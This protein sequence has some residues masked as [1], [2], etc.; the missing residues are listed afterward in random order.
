MVDTKM[1]ESRRYL[2]AVRGH[3]IPL[4]ACVAIALVLLLLSGPLFGRP[5]PSLAPSPSASPTNYGT[6]FIVGSIGPNGTIIVT[7]SNP[8]D[9]DILVHASCKTMTGMSVNDESKATKSDGSAK[10]VLHLPDVPLTC[11]LTASLAGNETAAPFAS[12]DIS[13]N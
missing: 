6:S 9:G 10:V 7:V 8:P 5:T 3:S 13:R 4:I 12:I 1:S 2:A 11:T